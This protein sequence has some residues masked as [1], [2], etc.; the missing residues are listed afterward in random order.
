MPLATGMAL[1][2]TFLTIKQRHDEKQAAAATTSGKDQY[3][4]LWP[5]IDQKSCLKSIHTAGFRPIP[6]PM[7]LNGDELCTDLV[8]LEEAL[9]KHTTEFPNACVIVMTTTSC[10]APRVPDR[11]ADVAMLCAQ[12]GVAY[13]G[14]IPFN[15]R[16]AY[17]HN[18]SEQRIWTPRPRRVPDSQPGN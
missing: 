17:S 7:K 4:V 8:A 15:E 5:R 14:N 18:F 10:F 2:L 1:T 6:I 11:V 13:V 12:Y 3:V 16:T 9:K